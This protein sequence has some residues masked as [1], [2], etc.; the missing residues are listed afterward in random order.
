MESRAQVSIE[1]LLMALFGIVLALTAALLIDTIR[2]VALTAQGKI[3]AYR[4]ET[5]ASLI[6]AP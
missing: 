3:L 6:N 1:Y 5:I 2:G 4:D